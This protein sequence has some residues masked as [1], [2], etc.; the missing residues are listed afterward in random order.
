MESCTLWTVSRALPL[1]CLPLVVALVCIFAPLRAFAADIYITYGVDGTPLLTNSPPQNLD[2]QT[3]GEVYA[4]VDVWWREVV[5]GKFLS[6]G[7]PMP[8]LDRIANLND[9]DAAFLSAAGDTGLPA[10]L[11]KAVAVTESR[12][13]PKAVSR[14]GARGLMQLI[15]ST[16]QHMGVSDTFDPIQSIAGGAAYLAKQVKAFGSYELALA[17]YNAGPNAVVKYA[18]V[19]PYR[20]TETYVARVIGLYELFRDTRPVSP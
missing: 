4:D 6:N 1:S 15:P 3:R 11:I 20:E 14:A 2:A 13:N 17:A 9:Y 18:G 7:V 5:P 19:P 16:A 10:E 12:M 8:N